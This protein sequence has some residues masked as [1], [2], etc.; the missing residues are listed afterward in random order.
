MDVVQNLKIQFC[1]YILKAQLSA[2]QMSTFQLAVKY[3]FIHAL[4]LLAVALMASHFDKPIIV[5]SGWWFVV[6][7]VL[8]S[9]SLY[10][11]CFLPIRWLGFITPFGGVLLIVA[12]VLLAVSAIR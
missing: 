11:L 3:Q 12:W 10:A 6:G 4:A 9:G 1:R 2:N 7:T 8:F 5:V